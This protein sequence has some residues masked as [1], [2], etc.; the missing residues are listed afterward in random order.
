[1]DFD[2]QQIE[3]GRRLFAQDSQFMLGV[4]GLKQLPDSTLPEI[5]FAGRS[6]VGKSSLINALSGRK[7]L[8][9]TSHSPGRTRE[10]NFFKLGVTQNSGSPD[11]VGRMIMVDMPG[12]GYARAAKDD[13]R[14]W[15]DL[16]KEYLRGRVQ[17]RRVCLLID[18]RHGLKDSDR[19]LMDMLDDT[20]V[21]YQIILTKIDKVKVN[22]LEGTKERIKDEIKKRAAA[23]PVFLDTSAFKS[24]GIENL[25]ASLAS[26]AD[27]VALSGKD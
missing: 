14:R 18:A 22:M 5:A 16:I 9:R 24:M 10:L 13:I 2:D 19:E 1:M 15:N 23:F 21:S 27:P 3:Y 7:M 11:A 4:A 12:Y 17:L 25:R 8:A 26:I 6:N 20:A